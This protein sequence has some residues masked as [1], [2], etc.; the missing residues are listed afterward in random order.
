MNRQCDVRKLSALILAM[1]WNVLSLTQVY[2]V[3]YEHFIYVTEN[4]GQSWKRSDLTSEE[5]TSL[6]V[7]E[8]LEFHPESQFDDYVA[9][10]SNER[11]VSSM[12]YCF[13]LFS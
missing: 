7:D 5:K 6:S 3:S 2:L 13:H 11:K 9:V 1:T 4:G 8:Q 12:G 10:I